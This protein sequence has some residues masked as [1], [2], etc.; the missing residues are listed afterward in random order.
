MSLPAAPER[1]DI[2]EVN[3]ERTQAVAAYG[4]TERQARFLVTVMIHA[5]VFVERQY[6]AFA[7]IAH[8]QKTHDFLAKLAGHGYA[9]PTEV[10][11]LHRGRFFHV[12]YKPLYAA[13]GEPDNRNRKRAP[14]GR[15][16]ERLMLLDAVLDDRNRTW[17]GTEGDKCRYFVRHLRDYTVT[18]DDFPH[19]TFGREPSRRVRH[20]PDKLPIGLPAPDQD[21]HV[22]Q[23]LVN[24]P[25]PMDFRMFL[26]RHAA[27]LRL[28]GKWTVR[29]L[30]PEP[31]AKA[32][33]LFGHAARDQVA[34]PIRTLS[35]EEWEWY[36]RERRRRNEGADNESPEQEDARFKQAASMFRGPRFEAMYRVWLEQGDPILW[37][38]P[39]ARIREQ[40]EYH[41]GRF[42]FVRLARQYL[43]LSS[44]VGVA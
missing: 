43:H 15:Q 7:G 5:G 12:H 8:G 29:V 37:A 9:T 4:F 13:I 10:G 21:D 36:C 35:C 31:F 11:P 3:E 17:V 18:L 44:L 30:F 38:A 14:I 26:V 40:L 6:C 20:F 33:T 1:W 23:Y 25:H 41:D 22:F 34:N 16:I 28:L 39:S 2:R 24:K 27:V 19:L 32:R 42:E